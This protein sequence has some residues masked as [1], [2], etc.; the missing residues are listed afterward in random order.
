ML[1]VMVFYFF[2]VFV[3]LNAYLW[4]ASAENYLFFVML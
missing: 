2:V 1:F 4:C 3:K